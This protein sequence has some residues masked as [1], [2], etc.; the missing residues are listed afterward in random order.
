MRYVVPAALLVAAAVLA[1]CDEDVASSGRIPRE[2]S[3]ATAG[4]ACQ[5]LEYDVVESEL[6]VRFDTAGS[7][8]VGDT[9][10]CALTRTEQAYP[11][12]IVSI[13]PTTADELIF[14]TA[15]AP[16]RSTAVKGLGLIAYRSSIA[17]SGDAGSGIEIG[18]LTRS[19]R[20]VIIRYT[21]APDTSADDLET[22]YP[23]LLTLAR[24]IDA[25]LAPQPAPSSTPSSA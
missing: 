25:T 24:R 14:R 13:S 8:R 5:L 15:V 16:D 20:I 18:W 19:G 12:L 3:A 10:T 9:V 6:G 1:G 17:P 21:V 11:D 23:S 4:M 22:I 2:R 7:A